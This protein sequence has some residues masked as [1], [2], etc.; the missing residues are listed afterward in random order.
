[1]NYNPTT[2]LDAVN[3]MLSTIGEA[4]VSSLEVSGLTDVAIAKTI[5]GETSRAVQSRG[6]HF[7]SETNY[8]LSPTVDGHLL[9]P[10]NTLRIDPTREF[11]NYDLTQRGPKLYNRVDHTSVFTSPIKFDL[12]ILLVFDEMPEAARYYIAVR[13]A[14]IFQRRMLGSEAMEQFT[15]EEEGRALVVLQEAEGDTGDHNVLSG[16]HSVAGILGR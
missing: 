15:A 16:S 4:P 2:E 11:W 7:N 8:E 9:P 6:W 3:V 1:M 14:R 13:A 10:A 5:L 12:L